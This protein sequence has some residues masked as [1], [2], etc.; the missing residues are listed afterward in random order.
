MDIGETFD[1]IVR[2]SQAACA[3][4]KTTSP[5]SRGAMK[6]TLAT[7]PAPVADDTPREIALIDPD[8]RAKLRQLVCEEVPWPLFLHGQAGRGKTA[9]VLCLADRVP[10]AFYFR[11]PRLLKS[12]L[13][14]TKEGGIE[15]SWSIA[16]A[17]EVK[18]QKV[19]C[20]EHSF[21]RY[22]AGTPLLVVDDVAT[23]S[24][25][26]DAQYDNFY[27]VLEERKFKPTVVVSNL[28]L[29]GIAT[30]FD[31]RVASRLARGTAF[32]LGGDDRR[33]A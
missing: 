25:Y 29:N 12:F 10:G 3:A 2:Q 19:K 30:V 5:R 17:G 8:L 16:E 20:N 9:A 33:L 31:D 6:L 26:T 15:V 11:F 24:G 28:D 7:A 4:G 32:Q 21:F 14:A 22:L 1:Q 23:R 18:R 27:E 13:W